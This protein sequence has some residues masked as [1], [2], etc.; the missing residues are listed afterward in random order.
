[1]NELETDDDNAS[2]T[3]TPLKNVL[4]VPIGGVEII[5]EG[6]AGVLG[7]LGTVMDESSDI[8]WNP[9]GVALG[10]TRVGYPCRLCLGSGG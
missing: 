10:R 6:F 2:I 4:P 1:M 5:P 7:R 8:R 9:R 3:L